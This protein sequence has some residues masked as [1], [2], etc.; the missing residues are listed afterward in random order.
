MLAGGNWARRAARVDWVVVGLMSRRVMW[1][2]AVEAKWAVR[3]WPMPEA[4]PVVGYCQDGVIGMEIGVDGPVTMMLLLD[5]AV[6]V[7]SRCKGVVE[8]YLYL[9]IYSR[10]EI[11]GIHPWVIWGNSGDTRSASPN[12]QSYY[13]TVILQQRIGM[14][15]GVI[16][17]DARYWHLKYFL[18]S[19]AVIIPS[20][21]GIFNTIILALGPKNATMASLPLYIALHP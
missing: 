21:G 2:F 16:L 4:P 19:Y 1:V 11:S 12:C 15:H 3:A 10:L 9:S 20:P 7:G 6:S 5:M 18:A 8:G 14:F 13:C 17:S